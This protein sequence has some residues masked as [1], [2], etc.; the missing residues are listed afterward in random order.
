MK[1][2][3]AILTYMPVLTYGS[4]L[5]NDRITFRDRLRAD[6]RLAVEY[7]DLKQRLAVTHRNHRE[8]YTEAKT[9]FVE[10]VLRTPTA[11]ASPAK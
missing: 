7:A 8:A 5:W 3:V 1:P 2:A 10:K 4:A 6:E 9:G 11:I